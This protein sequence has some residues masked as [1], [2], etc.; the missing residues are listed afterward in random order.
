MTN[1]L[2][3]GWRPCAIIRVCQTGRMRFLS[4][5]DLVRV[6]DR[7]LRRAKLPVAYSEGF[8]PHAQISFASPLPLGVEGWREP[9]VVGLAE[10]LAAEQVKTRLQPVLPSDFALVD[11]EITSRGRRSPL[12]DF[13]LAFYRAYLAPEIDLAP[14]QEAVDKLLYRKTWPWQRETKSRVREVDLRPGILSVG[15]Q[16]TPEPYLEMKLRADP[17]N[18]V[19]LEEVLASLALL[20]GEPEIS[21][22]RLARADLRKH[23]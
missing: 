15:L 13:N 4:H 17:D 7:A 23:S 14:L 22:T 19:K 8:H 3:P 12:A 16:A 2:P 1:N 11:V 20:A 18:L 10:R 9:V 21:T 5:L 6:L